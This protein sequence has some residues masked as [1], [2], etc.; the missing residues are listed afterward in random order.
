MD[1][2]KRQMKHAWCN[3]MYYPGVSGRSGENHDFCQDSL[4]LGLN[5]KAGTT[6]SL[7]IGSRS[8]TARSGCCEYSANVERRDVLTTVTHGRLGH[9]L[10]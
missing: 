3:V 1:C 4:S 10:I 8:Y 6:P 7:S 2:K 5:L 9:A